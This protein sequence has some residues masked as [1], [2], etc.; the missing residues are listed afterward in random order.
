MLVRGSRLHVELVQASITLRVV[1]GPV[2]A[3]RVRETE[4]EVGPNPIRVDLAHS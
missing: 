1:E 2:L 3:V 4:V